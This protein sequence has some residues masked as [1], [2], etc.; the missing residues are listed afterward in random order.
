M[1]FETSL[2]KVRLTSVEREMQDAQHDRIS[3]DVVFEDA[4]PK[5]QIDDIRWHGE[6]DGPQFR[7][8]GRNNDSYRIS[9]DVVRTE[10]TMLFVLDS[11][12]YCLMDEYT[13]HLDLSR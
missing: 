12:D 5:Y 4:D 13:F 8:G 11:I 9:C 1:V 7:Y 10:D 2:G 3:F 6:Y